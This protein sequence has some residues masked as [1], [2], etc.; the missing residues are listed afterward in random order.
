MEEKKPPTHG[1]FQSYRSSLTLLLKFG[2]FGDAKM[3]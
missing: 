1:F 3:A 2:F